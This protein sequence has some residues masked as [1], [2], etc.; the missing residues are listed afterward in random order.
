MVDLVSWHTYYPFGL[1]NKALSSGESSYALHHRY[2]GAFAEYDEETKLN[3]FE[4]RQYD[5]VTGRWLSTDPHGQH[6]SPYL[7]MG[8]NPASYFDPDDGFDKRIGA[9]WYSLWNGG[10]VGGNKQDGF[11]VSKVLNDGDPSQGILNTV[12]VV[13]GRDP[14]QIDLGNSA[15]LS[16]VEQQW[17]HNLQYNEG[18]RAELGLSNGIDPVYPET[19]LMPTAP[20]KGLQASRTLYTTYKTTRVPGGSRIG[21]KITQKAAIKLL[22]QKEDVYSDSR[23]EAKSLLQRAGSRQGQAFSE[24]SQGSVMYPH[25]HMKRTGNTRKDTR[26]PFGHSFYGSPTP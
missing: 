10:T 20:I 19:Y 3:F 6:W 4:L 9:W 16:L 18:L 2:Q 23:S 22:R 7:A 14:N 25:Y 24:T 13:T 21:K 15:N 12:E 5:A 1:E 26:L 17:N 8:N 11:T